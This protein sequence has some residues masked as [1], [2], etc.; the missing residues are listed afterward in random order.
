MFLQGFHF[1]TTLQCKKKKKKGSFR[2]CVSILLMNIKGMRKVYP[3]LLQNAL[4][5]TIL[6]SWQWQWILP[7]PQSDVL[8]EQNS[9]SRRNSYISKNILIRFLF[10]TWGQLST[11]HPFWEQREKKTWC[12][13]IQLTYYLTSFTLFHCSIKWE[14]ISY[15]NK[16]IQLQPLA[17]SY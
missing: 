12:S 5:F 3:L 10:M 4:L 7:T 8:C 6:K 1:C 15:I 2:L 11:C 9:R 17:L 16:N 14:A 13:T